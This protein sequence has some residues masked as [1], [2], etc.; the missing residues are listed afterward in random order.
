MRATYLLRT[1]CLVGVLG[2]DGGSPSKVA[3]GRSGVTH[4]EEFVDAVGNVVAL[5]PR[6][7]QIDDWAVAKAVVYFIVEVIMSVVMSVIMGIIVGVIVCVIVEVIVEATV[8]KSTVEAA[9]VK[10]TVEAAITESTVEA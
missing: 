8:A 9:V 6:V 10:S 1:L 2:V 3:R 7:V 4:P 5:V